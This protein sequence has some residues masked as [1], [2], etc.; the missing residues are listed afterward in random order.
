MSES[1]SI[2]LIEHLKKVPDP[3]VE[4]GRRHKLMDLLVIALCA[5]LGG[6]DD[7]VE[8]VQF[9]Q[10]KKDWFATFLELHN[11]IAS[12]D[13]F[14][15]VFQILDSKMLEQV[16]MQWLQSIAGQIEGVVAIDGKSLRGSRNGKQS[17]LHIV[18]AWA[19]QNSMLLGQVQTDKKS[20]EI[21][22]IPALLKLLSL[23]GCIVTIDAMGCQK[24]I[25]QA[26]I[27]S[28]ADYVLNLKSNHPYLHRQVASW[29]QKNRDTGF[30][31]QT[32]SYSLEHAQT[33]NH[34]RIESR[35]H[36]LMEVPEYLRRATKSWTKL[37]TIAMV[38]RTR[39][40]GDKTSEET[41]YYISSLP[42]SAGAKS[43]AKAIRSHW[44]VENELHWSLDVAFSE[45][46]SQTRKGEGP[47]NLACIRR[48]ALTQLKRE[49]SLK[50]GLKN[51]RSRAGWD[52]AYME[53]VL[54]NGVLSI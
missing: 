19:C 4:R 44:A 48:L 2:S 6:A 27:D 25:T 16:C 39:Q 15:R 31:Q 34:G 10:A 49:K 17:P 13:T 23:K 3:R 22:A 24:A 38:R 52:P 36:W 18:S 9:G 7:W 45:D 5:T 43:I 29:F 35:E 40:V 33:N 37:Q 26:I 8:I 32:Y 20:N 11:G 30:D 21:T 54:R 46:A 51:K 50:V 47:A 12:H 28:E 41:H 1:S 42:L 14:G 53:T